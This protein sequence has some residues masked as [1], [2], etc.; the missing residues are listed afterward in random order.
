MDELRHFTAFAAAFTEPQHAAQSIAHSGQASHPAAQSAHGVA[1]QLGF[2]AT[3]L[4]K[5]IAATAGPATAIPAPPQHALQSTAHRGQ[6]S[7]P[8]A[9]AAH[10]VAQQ[11]AFAAVATVTFDAQHDF[12]EQSVASSWLCPQA[13]STV[14]FTCPML[15]PWQ[16]DLLSTFPYIA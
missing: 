12:A 16:P 4:T 9:H 6:P 7:H 1:Q 13:G 5:F 11:V 8:A 3:V 2:A 15:Q 14:A 10:G